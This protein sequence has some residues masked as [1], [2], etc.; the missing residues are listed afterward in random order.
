MSTEISEGLYQTNS[1]M[2]GMNSGRGPKELD[3]K[4]GVRAVK[5]DDPSH[6]DQTQ[7]TLKVCKHEACLVYF[8]LILFRKY[9]IVIFNSL[10]LEVDQGQV[11]ND[12]ITES[13]VYSTLG[14]IGTALFV[15][16]G[17]SLTKG[18]PGTAICILVLRVILISLQS[19]SQQA[20]SL[21]SRYGVRSY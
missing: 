12:R 6:G 2:T 19:L 8:N 1:S 14:T 7:R 16:I 3:T 4:S 15:Q 5:Q 11:L 18:G 13:L 17:S 20:C 9:R 10:E 21:R